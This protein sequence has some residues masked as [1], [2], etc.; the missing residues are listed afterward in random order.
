MWIKQADP[1]CVAELFHNYQSAL[2]GFGPKGSE[3]GSWN[4]SAE[5]NETTVAEDK[6]SETMGSREHIASRYRFRR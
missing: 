3:C 4:D 1:A 2:G 6:E 5:K